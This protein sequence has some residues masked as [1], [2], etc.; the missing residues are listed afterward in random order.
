VRQVHFN[1]VRQ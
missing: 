1:V